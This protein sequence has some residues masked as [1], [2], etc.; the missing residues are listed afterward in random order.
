M[1]VSFNYFN[2]IVVPEPG[3]MALA[4]IGAIGLLLARFRKQ[5]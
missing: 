1:D 2:V 3:S 4:G 5:R